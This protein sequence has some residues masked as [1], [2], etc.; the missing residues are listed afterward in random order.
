MK[1]PCVYI[2]T[3]KPNGTFYVG[4]T[5]NIMKRIW[6]HKNNSVESFTSKHDLHRLVWFEL[7]ETMDSA[8]SRE[9]SVKRWKRLWKKRLIESKNP[10]WKD[11]F[12][13]LAY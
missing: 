11:L 5:S 9:K 12:K 13:H 8:I 7:H 6:E 3:N 4:V 10:E 1:T 2:L